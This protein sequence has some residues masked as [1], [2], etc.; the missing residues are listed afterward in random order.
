MSKRNTWPILFAAAVVIVTLSLAQPSLSKE[1]GYVNAV[2]GEARVNAAGQTEFKSVKAGDRISLNDSIQTDQ[3]SKIHI[4]LDDDS[5]N[6]LGELSEINI[7]DFERQNAAQYYGADVTSGLIRFVKKLA[8]TNPLSSYTVTTPTAIINVESGDKADFVVR[9]FS[10]KRTTVT[11]IWGKVRV[12]NVS[13]DLATERMVGSCRRVDVEENKIPSQVMG[14][15]S[16][17][18]K[19]LITRT[20]IPGTLS[21]DVPSCGESFVIRK[22]CPRRHIWDGERCVPCREFGLIYEDGKC[23]PPDCGDCRLL[24]GWRCVACRELGMVCLGGQCVQRACPP[25]S[26]WNG[27]RCVPCEEFGRVCVAGRCVPQRDCP[28]CSVWNGWRCVPC[29]QLGRVCIDG[30]CLF[31]PCGLCEVRRGEACVPC[32]ALGLNCEMGRC[33]Q[34]VVAPAHREPGDKI[35]PPPLAPVL[36]PAT[37]SPGVPPLKPIVGPEKPPSVGIKEPL[38]PVAPVKPGDKIDTKP[39]TPKPESPT[40]KKPGVQTTPPKPKPIETT[41][42]LKF[43]QTKPERAPREPI[44]HEIK[45]EKKENKQERPVPLGRPD[46]K[47]EFGK[48]DRAPGPPIGERPREDE[49]KKP[50]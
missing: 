36:P 8:E 9:V 27:R 15:S 17:T 18:L 49:K 10:Q 3:S 2:E 46:L 50:H 7:Y 4:K 31:R 47:P 14:V 21:E 23:V 22:E 24:W 43:D 39:E 41:P 13:E 12:K 6:S 16:R 33:V 28:P 20:T 42:P 30:R 5:H 37:I 11:V 48:P 45:Q 38:K 29:A 32:N 40:H 1:V 34:P 44:K 25:C 26:I 19:D 35:A